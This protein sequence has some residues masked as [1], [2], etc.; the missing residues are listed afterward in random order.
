MDP[1]YCDP[2]Y[3]DSAK[4]GSCFL[5]TSLCALGSHTETLF[6]L[7]YR[8]LGIMVVYMGS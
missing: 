3:R 2:Y 6:G 4:K 7:I 5:E 8:G 1:K